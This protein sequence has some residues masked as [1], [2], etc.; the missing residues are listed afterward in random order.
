MVGSQLIGQLQGAC[1]MNSRSRN[2]LRMLA[3]IV[4][5]VSSLIVMVAPANADGSGTVNSPWVPARNIHTTCDSTTLFGNYTPG[6]G[7]SNP[8]AVLPE[9]TWLSARYVTSDGN[10]V[11][12]LWNGGGVWGFLLQSCIAYY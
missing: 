3:V 6:Q 8:I 12:A 9:A 1:G 2:M 4:A 5:L 10:S 7:H 11:M